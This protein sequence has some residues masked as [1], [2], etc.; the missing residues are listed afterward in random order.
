MNTAA[1][2]KR[3]ASNTL[4]LYIRMLI[5]MC[6]TLYTSRVVL[7]ALGVVDYGIYNVVGGLTA[8]FA[9][10]TSFAAS[11]YCSASSITGL[12]AF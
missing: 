11:T 2:S 7:D 10:F 6:V 1:N 3:V 8:S 5:M 4:F 9:F 12:S